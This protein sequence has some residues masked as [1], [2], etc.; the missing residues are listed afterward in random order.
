MW[1]GKKQE[2]KNKKIEVLPEESP[3]H[4]NCCK[5]KFNGL[6]FKDG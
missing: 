1:K 5:E 4:N 3:R 6:F 2:K